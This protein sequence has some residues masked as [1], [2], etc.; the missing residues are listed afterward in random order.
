MQIITPQTS[1]NPAP[2]PLARESEAVK[3]VKVC[4]RDKS[5][6]P[7]PVLGG[8]PVGGAKSN[9]FCFQALNAIFVDTSTLKY[10]I[11]ES[12]SILSEFPFDN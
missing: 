6:L 3:G 4:Q 7:R 8:D 5:S 12:G 2:G 10:R 1:G 11:T 9:D